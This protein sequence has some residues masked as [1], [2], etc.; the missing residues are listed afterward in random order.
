VLFEH[1]TDISK[2]YIKI[3]FN[4]YTEYLKAFKYIL[5]F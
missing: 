5:R 3:K 2:S 4:Y 1:E